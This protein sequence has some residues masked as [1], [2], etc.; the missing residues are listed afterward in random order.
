MDDLRKAQSIPKEHLSEVHSFM[1]AVHAKSPSKEFGGDEHTNYNKPIEKK[2]ETLAPKEFGGDE[3]TNYGHDMN[4]EV[5]SDLRKAQSIP[6]E[7]H[8][9]IKKII[10]LHKSKY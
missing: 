3:Y 10:E 2:Q 8:E 7:H 5:P 1:K 6:K 4:K 9:K